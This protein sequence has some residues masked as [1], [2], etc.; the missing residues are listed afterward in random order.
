MLRCHIQKDQVR[1]EV[2]AL[3]FTELSGGAP[4]S[5]G[6]LVPYKVSLQHKLPQTK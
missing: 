2:T 4:I 5:P 6:K 3:S 1:S